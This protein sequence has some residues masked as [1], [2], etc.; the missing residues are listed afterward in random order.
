MSNFLE[1][2]GSWPVLSVEP[3]GVRSLESL[4]KPAN[5]VQGNPVIIAVRG[6][7]RHATEPQTGLLLTY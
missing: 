1:L 7:R 6:V 5:Q 4:R 2:V 3:E